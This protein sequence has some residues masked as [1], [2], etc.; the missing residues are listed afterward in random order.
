M[1]KLAATVRVVYMSNRIQ[2]LVCPHFCIHISV[3]RAVRETQ[4]GTRALVNVVIMHRNPRLAY[5]NERTYKCLISG[6]ST[7]CQ[8][9]TTTC[10]R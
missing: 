6:I 4:G 8:E 2:R 5:V 10:D 7:P 1:R 9:K 3:S